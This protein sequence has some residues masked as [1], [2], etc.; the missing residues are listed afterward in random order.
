MSKDQS[1]TVHTL[2]EQET[3]T[4]KFPVKNTIIIDQCIATVKPKRKPKIQV[5]EEEIDLK[6]EEEDLTELFD[7]CAPSLCD[8]HYLPIDDFVLNN[9]CFGENLTVSIECFDTNNYLGET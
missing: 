4:P 6:Q 9:I 2:I 5:N 1:K 7:F 3:T 8:I